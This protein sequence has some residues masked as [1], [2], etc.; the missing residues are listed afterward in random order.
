MMYGPTTA[1]LGAVLSLHSG[2]SDIGAIGSSSAYSGKPV[3]ILKPMSASLRSHVSGGAAAKAKSG[4]G[5][6]AT[7]SA[8]SSGA[9]NSAAT[10]SGSSGAASGNANANASAGGASPPPF[11]E[12]WAST[13]SSVPASCRYLT[14][15]MFLEGA[16]VTGTRPALPN[17]A[18]YARRSNAV[19]PGRAAIEWWRY[20]NSLFAPTGVTSAGPGGV[21]NYAMPWD[22]AAVAAVSKEWSTWLRDYRAAGGKLD[23]LVG[24]SERWQVFSSWS[25]SATHVA[26]IA[27]DPR[28]DIAMFGIAP[29]RQLLGNVRFD[30]VTKPTETTD[31]L[32]WNQGIGTLT[33]A[34]MQRGIWDPAVA[35]YPQLKG[36]NY[37]GVVMTNKPA[38]DLNGHP[39]G[40]SNVFG[41]ASAP[42]LY[43][44]VD[45][46]ATAW[47]VSAT[48][49]TQLS[50][51]GSVRIDR[52]GWYSFVVDQQFARACRRSDPTR[53]LQPWIALN[54]WQG[55]KA[56]TVGYASDTR[57]QDESVRQLALLGTENYLYWNPE[58]A[59]V[60][61]SATWTA[62]QRDAAAVRLDAVI[63]D[64]NTRTHGVIVSTVAAPPISFDTQ[65][66]IT[67]AKR[68]DGKWIWRTTVRPD[69]I[70]LRDVTTGVVAD[71]EPGGMGRWDVTNSP[72]APRFE[73][74]IA[75]SQWLASASSK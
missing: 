30:K 56:G 41:T 2:L 38:P 48:D 35:L 43:G 20:A 3:T 8:A 73:V 42:S 19:P 53:P 59:K 37:A 61:P 12:I 51:S 39:Q 1:I 11:R 31:Y 44:Q 69:V 24:D 75:S 14:P 18:D 60:G 70:Q 54:A 6:A 32:S 13:W 23:V 58:A 71:L 28:M 66:V 4:S 67:G 74:S 52:N 10:R 17:A 21:T 46:A 9:S 68:R 29:L 55:D 33:A 72:T 5:S 22:E 27:A 64:I 36:S 40:A 57:Y 62:A 65:V 47:Y 34:A 25:L 45:G 63:G 50:K 15:M 7:A 49:P 16:F 26:R